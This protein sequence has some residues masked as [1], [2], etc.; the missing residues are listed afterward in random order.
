MGCWPV[1]SEESPGIQS[2]PTATRKNRQQSELEGEKY[3]V[4]M[5]NT[6]QL[7]TVLTKHEQAR[8]GLRMASVSVY[9]PLSLKPSEAVKVMLYSLVFI[10][11][12][13]RPLRR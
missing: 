11:F 8:G 6:T 10:L 1:N 7:V 13:P 2:Q 3:T 12:Y 4:E 9:A 5:Y